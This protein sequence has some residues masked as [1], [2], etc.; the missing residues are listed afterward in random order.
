MHVKFLSFLCVV[1]FLLSCKSETEEY[2][3]AEKA[4]DVPE[5]VLLQDDSTNVAGHLQIK[6]SASEVNLKWNV[7]ANCNLDTTQSVA[8][9]VEGELLLPI[10]WNERVNNTFGPIDKVFNVGVTISTNRFT[11]Y[12][13]L[14]WTQEIDSLSL[15]ESIHSRAVGVASAPVVLTAIPE[16]IPMD[17]EF[18]SAVVVYFTGTPAVSIDISSIAPSTNI[19][20]GL[21][22]LTLLET[23]KEIPIKWNTSGA[24]EFGF[25]TQ[26]RISA[27][28]IIMPVPISYTVTTDEPAYWA[29]SSSDP[30]DSGS[31]AAKDAKVIV[32][33]KTNKPWSIECTNGIISPINDVNTDL[34]TRSLTINIE[35]NPNNTSRPI[36]VVIKSQGEVKKTLSFIQVANSGS[37]GDTGTDFTFVSSEPADKAVISA[38]ESG[39]TIKVN[40][41]Y[42]WWIDLNGTKSNFPASALGEKIGTIL[43]PANTEAT[44]KAITVTVGHGSTIVKTLTFTQN[45]T[46]GGLD[47][48]LTYVNSNL[49][50]GNIPAAGKVYTFTFTGDYTGNFRVRVIDATTNGVINNGPIGTTLTPKATVTANTA[51]TTRNIKFQYRKTDVAT[52]QWI[53]LPALTNRIQDA[54]T[55]GG[56]ETGTVRPGT[57]GPEGDL[58]EYG[59]NC[60][61][62]FDGDFT[63]TIIMRAK[64]GE[65]ELARSIGKANSTITVQIPKLDGMDRTITLEYSLDGGNTWIPL[66]SKKQINEIFLPSG[67]QPVV[68]KI[69]V[70]GGDFSWSYRGTYSKEVQFE[71]ATVEPDGTYNVLSLQSSHSACTFTYT[72]PANT[73]TQRAI[74]FRYKMG[75]KENWTIIRVLLQD[76][77]K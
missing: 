32:S 17:R 48:E 45:G 13:P 56:S 55:G 71:V 31:L 63:G 58:S 76:G 3:N 53:D 12:V 73:G 69:S 60:S 2:K 42:A 27:P 30:T 15:H 72:V 59:D 49:P 7:P 36:S 66:G 18:G 22:P 21:I 46:S 26:L 4:L 35:D 8:S 44:S 40:T 62:K 65:Q 75:T 61:C 23:G 50:T 11:K 28:G 5:Y 38:T 29:F 68:D 43:L 74:G 70:K 24:P 25:T 54:D 41:D 19:D 6:S 33:C 39:V 16:L 77:S 10:H 57:L 1:L 9:I 51:A 47:G 14:L 34:G 20:K 67:L 64:V 37:G 52:A